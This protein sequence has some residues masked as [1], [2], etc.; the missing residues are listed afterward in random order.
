MIAHADV[1]PA[2]CECAERAER[3][4]IVDGPDD[5]VLGFAGP[6][7]PPHRLEGVRHLAVAFDVGDRHVLQVRAGLA[8]ADEH[9]GQSHPRQVAGALQRDQHDL[10]DVGLPLLF[11]PPPEVAAS[12]QTGFVVVGAKV[13]RARM[14]N[15]ERDQRDVGFAVLGGDDRR[16]VFVGLKLDDEI[17]LFPHQ[18]VGV[19]LAILPL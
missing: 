2:S 14:W 5:D 8:H 10:V 6:Q 9:P 3:A 16:D 12:D 1:R 4:R 13:G 18:H 19:A 15:L 17:D 11:R 7:V